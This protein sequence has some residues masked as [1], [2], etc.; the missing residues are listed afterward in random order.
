[1]PN[2]AL[3][4]NSQ[5]IISVFGSVVDG[6]PEVT[7]KIETTIGGEPLEDGREVTDH[8]VAKQDKI[9]MTGW[10]SD[11]NGGN[12]PKQAW[13]RIRQIQR[14]VQPIKVIT[15][16]GVYDEM[17]IDRA[18]A[19]QTNRGMNFTLELREIRRV[20]LTQSTIS[21]LVSSGPAR[22]RSSNVQRGRVGF[23]GGS[24]ATPLIV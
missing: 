16:W 11:I 2:I 21:N 7:H 5:A 17:L 19:P 18:E 23:T 13:E 14:L 22:G 3:I 4:P 15:E 9:V 6:W 20:G 10:V 8:A 1:M 12:R 24:S